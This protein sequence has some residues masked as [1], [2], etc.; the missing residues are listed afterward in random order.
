MNKKWWK[1]AGMR[2][3]KT[4][5]QTALSM[6]TIG[7]AVLDV[8]WLNVLSVSAV[9]GIISLITSIAGLPEVDDGEAV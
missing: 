9:A 4:I 1:A 8:D 7:Q 3:I 6:L 5:C 2:A